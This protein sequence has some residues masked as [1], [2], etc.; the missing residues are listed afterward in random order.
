MM[1]TNP[2]VHII[3]NFLE[4]PDSQ[5]AFALA[6]RYPRRGPYPG[7]RTETPPFERGDYYK[8]RIE[9]IVGM[10]IL[11]W[12][13]RE[14][15]WGGAGNTVFHIAFEDDV[16]SIHYDHSEWACVLY[17]TPNPPPDSGTTI[18]RN[19]HSGAWDSEVHLHTPEQ[20]ADRSQWAVHEVLENRYNRL[21][22]YPGSIYHAATR[23]GF[24]TDLQSGRLTQVFFFSTTRTYW[25]ETR[26]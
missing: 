15:Q 7:Y 23:A 4:D 2:T 19:I 18:Y 3:D 25:K 12:P 26:D 13:K 10:P 14:W 11:Q 16:N 9:Q 20:L 6:Q 8:D 1:Q 21:V 17:L 24:G 22:M 5:R